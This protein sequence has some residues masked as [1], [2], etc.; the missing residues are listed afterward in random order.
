MKP[1]LPALAMHR[2]TGNARRDTVCEGG[3]GYLLKYAYDSRCGAQFNSL[4]FV[5]EAT[6][7]NDLFVT[8]ECFERPQGIRGRPEGSVVE[9]IEIRMVGKYYIYKKKEC[10]P[11][12][13]LY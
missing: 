6:R 10:S 7:H 2:G 5:R 9:D 12:L 13:Y 4:P 1:W 3:A 11:S 8:T